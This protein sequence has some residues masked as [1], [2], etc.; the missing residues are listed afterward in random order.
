MTLTAFCTFML[1]IVGKLIWSDIQ[2]HELIDF[3]RVEQEIINFFFW[4]GAKLGRVPDSSSI[5]V[6]AF[7]YQLQSRSHA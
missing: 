2:I 3:S 6:S 4:G 5:S 7:S 1:K